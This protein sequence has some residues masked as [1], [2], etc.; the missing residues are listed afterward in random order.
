MALAITHEIIIFIHNVIKVQ[1]VN[2]SKASVIAW[3]KTLAEFTNVFGSMNSRVQAIGNGII[4]RLEEHGKVAK[5][6]AICFADTLISDDILMKHL[7]DG[8]IKKCLERVENAV[9][10]ANILDNESCEQYHK[11]GL[12]L[13]ST[14]APRDERNQEAAVRSGKKITFLAKVVKVLATPGR[15]LLK[16]IMH[17]EVLEIIERVLVRVF[18]KEKDA[19]Q[20][21]N[22]YSWNFRSLRHLRILKNMAVSG[23]LWA[24]VLDAA[25]EEFTWAVSRTPAATRD[26]IVPVSK[27]FSLGVARFHQLHKSEE[28]VSADWLDFLKENEAVKIIQ[29]FDAALMLSLKNLCKDVKEMMQ[30]LPYYSRYDIELLQFILSN[31]YCL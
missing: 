12:T 21:I 31:Q 7:E 4:Q 30:I 29:E 11:I 1:Q 16:L 27:L 3:Q 28:N 25:D 22:I 15:S 9:V 17:N 8:D 5:V 10:S 2:M 6:R 26:Y 24:P 13:Y 19:S 14:L 20:V 18:E 23:G